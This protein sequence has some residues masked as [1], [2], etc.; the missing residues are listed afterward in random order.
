MGYIGKEPAA[1]SFEMLDD[2]TASAT[3]TYA[4]QK[5]SV[6][7]FPGSANQLIVSLNGV[8]QEPGVSFTISGSNIVFSSSLTSADSIDFILALGGVG[9]FGEPGD[10]SVTTAKI[11][12]D[13]V[14]SAKVADD[15]ITSALIA[16]DAIT[17]ALIADDAVG[18][19][20]IADDA[21]TSALIA[22]N[23]VVTAAI[24]GDAVTADK[25]ADD[26][27]ESEHLNDNVISGQTELAAEPADTDEFL[28]SDGG[29]LKRMDY[30]HIK[31][32][33]VTVSQKATTTSTGTFTI[34]SLTAN[35][36][37]FICGGNT[38][39]KAEFS[40]RVTSGTTAPLGQTHNT[41]TFFG[42]FS[43][44]TTSG[45]R[46]PGTVLIPTGTSIV[47]SLTQCVGTLTAFQ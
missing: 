5:G 14:T 19:A 9:D 6:A 4:L 7:F 15:A 36:P 8:V 13:A 42:I 28:V 34:S 31:A 44:D 43:D 1:G 24:N 30:S 10:A 40:F 2:L 16:D 32:G 23:A 3:A 37:V 46:V 45:R 21:I 29:V 20:A 26:A 47:L 39:D 18:S 11:A 35:I 25:I 22:D 27:V 41:S 12:D 33:A 17:S 38:A